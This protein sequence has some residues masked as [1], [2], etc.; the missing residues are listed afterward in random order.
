MLDSRKRSRR[1]EKFLAN[2]FRG[3]EQPASGAMWH[4]KGDVKTDR[5]LFEAK[6]TGMRSYSLSVE[7]MDKIAR[8]AI[9]T[10]RKPALHIRF[11]RERRDFVVLTLDD[12]E[13]LVQRGGNR[14]V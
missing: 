12:Y 9:G 7:T 2:K 3:Q 4:A 10:N 8:E 6:T 5:L 1:Q 11:E 13:E 14:G